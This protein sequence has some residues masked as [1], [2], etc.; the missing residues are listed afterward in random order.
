MRSRLSFFSL[1]S[2]LCFALYFS[3][4]QKD[5]SAATD[6]SHQLSFRDPQSFTYSANSVGVGDT[7]EIT[8]DAG[9]GADC[10]LV[11]IQVGLDGEWVGGRP[12]V[13]DSGLATLL[14]V[15][16][17]PGQYAVRAKYTRTGKPSSCDFESTKWLVSPD[18]ILVAQDTTT[19]DTTA[20][21]SCESSFTG[22]VITCDSTTR[23]VKYT[24]VSS[25]D[26]NHLKIKGGLTNGVQ[27]DPVVTVTGAD[28]DVEIKIPGH[29]TN[30]LITLTGDAVACDTITI[31]IM[32]T[33]TNTGQVITG[34]WSASGGDDDLEVAELECQ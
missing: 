29:S 26:L 31:T 9:N 21:D 23:E 10:G 32:W 8:F 5:E 16:D 6:D 7:V 20:A 25:E 17:A 30:R 2:L 14:F 13:P 3:S 15:P 24:F 1:F 12:V 11:M 34:D 28:L 33:S 18:S 4:C 19:Q 27:G 22:E